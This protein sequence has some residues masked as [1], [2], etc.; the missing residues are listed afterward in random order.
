MKKLNH[1]FS[2]RPFGSKQFLVLFL[3][4]V[5]LSASIPWSRSQAQLNLLNK[6][7]LALQQELNGNSNLLWSN[8]TSQRMRVLVQTNGLVSSALTNALALLDGVVVRQFT[9]INGLLVDIPKSSVLTLAARPD[10]DRLTP[11]H[12][13]QQSASHLETVTGANGLRTY[14]PLTGTFNGLDGSGIGVAILDSGLM[15]NH[16]HFRGFLNLSRVAASTDIVSSNS[17]LA[18]VES[19]LGLSI[20][21]LNGNKDEYGHGSHVAGVAAGR[22]IGAGSSRGFNG[23]APGAHVIDVRVLD[24]RGIGQVSDVIA[25]IDWVIA[26]RLRHNIKVMNLSLGAASTESYVTDP[27]CR[28]ARR[29]VS[30]GITV[31]ASAGNHGLT[32]DGLERYG[33]IMAPGN[34]PS[35]ITVG[36]A[37]THQTDTRNDET[38]NHFSSRGPT[39]SHSIDA[40]NRKQY[41]NLLKPD[42]VAPGNRIIAAESRDGFLAS[43]Y[44]L[45]NNGSGVN[46]Y[47]QLSGTS[48]AAPAVAGAA[49][50][51]LQK[52]VGLTP[53]LIKAILQYTAQQ[54]PNANLSQ[55][56][57]GLLN[58][59]GAVRLATVLRTD[60]SLATSLG[61]IRVGDSLLRAGA[62][63]PTPT[64]TVAGQ[65]FNWGGY[66]FAGGSH[67]LAGS[68]LFRRYQAIYNPALVWVRDR[69]TLNDQSTTNRQLITSRVINADMLGSPYSVFTSGLAI[70][71]GI[72]SGQGLMMNQGIALNDG[73]V[74]SEG[75]TMSE[76]LTLSEG[77]PLGQGLT[78]SEGLTLS[79]SLIGAGLTLSEGLTM[80]ES[81]NI[82]EP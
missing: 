37:N 36:S 75:L 13:A 67:I 64:S 43:H 35:V 30:L 19:L 63:L 41:D 47:M 51:L 69:V 50:L 31:V 66:I 76:G 72:L 40:A 82:G 15:A 78:M 52:N 65:S 33:S 24:G 49:A 9:S 80:S 6:L 79:E 48:I 56:G 8:P 28:A 27:L 11:D 3:A 74:I 23:I 17:L 7:T 22:S 59:E 55:Q 29:A 44:P 81:H 39:R 45:H 68:E 38:I 5:L 42:L 18:Q 12:L 16:S 60:I 21:L 62:S 54:L 10:V 71:S 34:D 70:S 57:A 61:L 2:K 73:I 26:N 53:P 32:L 1:T 77:F 20:P 14:Q 58:I 25:G 4:L 46:A